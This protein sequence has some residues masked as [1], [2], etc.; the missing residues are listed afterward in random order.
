MSFWRGEG[1]KFSFTSLVFLHKFLHVFGRMSSE[2]KSSLYQDI[3]FS[4][5]FL[6]FSLNSIL[7]CYIILQEQYCISRR[8]ESICISGHTCQRGSICCFADGASSTHSK[9]TDILV[10]LLVFP[11]ALMHHL[12]S[13]YF[14][15]GCSTMSWSAWTI[16]FTLIFHTEYPPL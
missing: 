10:P 14:S 2:M 7:L 11:R 12:E 3:I 13:F 4:F 1:V 5:K 6:F 15:K 9:A 8:W 16:P